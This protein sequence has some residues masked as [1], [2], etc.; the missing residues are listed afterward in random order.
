MKLLY[1]GSKDPLDVFGNPNCRWGSPSYR[2]EEGEPDFVEWFPPGYHPP[3]PKPKH[4][5]LRVPRKATA[6]NP[7]PQNPNPNM[8]PYQFLT[9]TGTQNQVTTARVSR[10][11]KTTAEVYAEVTARLGADAPTVQNVTKTLLEV[12]LDWTAEGWTVEPLED[13]L[14]F[15]L[16]CGGSFENTDMQPT[17]DNMAHKPAA[18]WGDTGRARVAG[19]ITYE[20]QGHQGR[21][22]P[23][24]IHIIDNWMDT[25]DH[26]TAGKSVCITLGNKKGRL[27]FDRTAG[28]KVEFRKEDGTLVEATDYSTTGSAKINAQVPTGTTGII[29]ET[30]V[31]ML[32]NGTLRQGSYTT[33]LISS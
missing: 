28:S 6:D 29:I 27:E 22:K 25:P 9:R 1:Y 3:K 12:I 23:E 30:L 32:V 8:L 15:S 16:P 33:H 5:T 11:T 21:A 10:G 31:T 26:Y 14:G 2:I 13:L 18:N 19:S 20:G 4:R 17:F 7:N 24:I